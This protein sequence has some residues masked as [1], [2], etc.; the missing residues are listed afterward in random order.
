[1]RLNAVARRR[2]EG[3]GAFCHARPSTS[4]LRNSWD[5]KPQLGFGRSH[6]ERHEF[7]RLYTG[8]GWEGHGGDD[9]SCTLDYSIEASKQ[10]CRYDRYIARPPDYAVYCRLQVSM[11]SLQVGLGV[12]DRE[13][14]DT[15]PP[16]CLVCPVPED[17]HASKDKT[18]SKSRAVHP[19]ITFS[20]FSLHTLVIESALIHSFVWCLVQVRSSVDC[21]G[22]SLYRLSRDISFPGKGP[23]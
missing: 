12:S 16:R 9:L 20:P 14:C 7:C 8:C 21:P 10:G 6:R 23:R 3:A 4:T 18:C 2:R 15:T 22:R 5:G 19:T 13:A 17:Q 1:M 11:M